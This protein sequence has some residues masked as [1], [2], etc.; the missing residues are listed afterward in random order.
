MGEYADL[1]ERGEAKLI[2]VDEN[3]SRP[4]VKSIREM[5]EDDEDV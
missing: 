1:I 3:D 4:R 5:F 2:L